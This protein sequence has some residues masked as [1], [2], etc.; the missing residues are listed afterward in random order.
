MTIHPQ[1]EANAT[2]NA[3]HQRVDVLDLVDVGYRYAYSL[4]H[5]RQ[6]AEDLAQQACLQAVRKKRKTGGESVPVRRNPESV[7]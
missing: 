6:D 7:S 4:T 2:V 3:E 5:H 1:G